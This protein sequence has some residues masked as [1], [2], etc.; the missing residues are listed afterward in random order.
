MDSIISVFIPLH[1]PGFNVEFATFLR[2]S[3]KWLLIY[4]R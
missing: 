4:G 2:Q 3:E 1:R